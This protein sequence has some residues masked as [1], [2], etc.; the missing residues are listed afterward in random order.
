MPLESDFPG[1]ASRI[2][3]LRI[4]GF[5]DE[6]IE[7]AIV[8]RVE[9]LRRLGTSG[10]E[11]DAWLK[12]RGKETRPSLL[13]DFP[14]DAFE[15]AQRIKDLVETRRQLEAPVESLRPGLPRA[16][17]E[18]F[19]QRLGVT[20]EEAKGGLV[21]VLEGVKQSRSDNPLERLFGVLR[22][23]AGPIRTAFSPLTAFVTRPLA[24]EFVGPALRAVTP[25]H[26]RRDL[27]RF[28][29]Q[30]LGVEAP[31]SEAIAEALLDLF[32]PFSLFGRAPA[33]T[34]PPVPALPPGPPVPRA[35][36]PGVPPL[37]LEA[38]P[39]PLPSGPAVPLP[40]RVAPP[41]ALPPWPGAPTR[42][43]PPAQLE[44]RL[45]P[46]QEVDPRQLLLPF[47]GAI[48]PRPRPPTPPRPPTRPTQLDL[49]LS[50][51]QG[52]DPRQLRLAFEEAPLEAP[53]AP[54][55]FPPPKPEPAPSTV[56]KPA[57]PLVEEPPSHPVAVVA[58][59]LRTQR[60]VE[61]AASRRVQDVVKEIV[62]G[63]GRP[64]R[65]PA[66]EIAKHFSDDEARLVAQRRLLRTRG[67]SAEE[68]LQVVEQLPM[69]KV[70]RLAEA[71]LREFRAGAGG[72]RRGRPRESIE[73]VAERRRAIALTPEAL[74]KIPAKAE[75]LVGEMAPRISPPRPFEVGFGPPPTPPPPS[76]VISLAALRKAAAARGADIVFAENKFRVVESG[77]RTTT[78]DTLS[79]VSAYIS[80]MEAKGLSPVELKVA[81]TGDSVVE[82]AMK[83]EQLTPAHK[84][85]LERQRA[86]AEA[87]VK[88]T[89]L[90]DFTRREIPEPEAFREPVLRPGARLGAAED[91]A[92]L[93]EAQR[94]AEAVRERGL[95]PE[96][97]KKPGG[98][99][100]VFMD[101]MDKE[102]LRGTILYRRFVQKGFKA[103]DAEEHTFLGR[104]FGKSASE[105]GDFLRGHGLAP[106]IAGGA[107]GRALGRLR[108]RVG[109]VVGGE[110]AIER[111]VRTPGTRVKILNPFAGGSISGS[112]LVRTAV[113]D[114]RTAFAAYRDEVVKLSDHLHAARGPISD[115]DAFSLVEGTRLPSTP[116]E[117]AFQAEMQ[118]VKTDFAQ[119]AAAIGHPDARAL[120]FWASHP[121]DL[122]A[123]YQAYRQHIVLAR[124]FNKLDPVLQ[125]KLTPAE[126][127]RAERLMTDVPV[128]SQL[129]APQREF[130][131]KLFDTSG[132]RGLV[133]KF[134]D[135][136]LPR[137]L[138]D[139]YIT[140]R[141]VAPGS[142]SGAV[143]EIVDRT[144]FA[145]HHYPVKKLW[146]QVIRQ[147]PGTESIPITERGFL[148]RVIDQGM[149][150]VRPWDRK[151][152]EAINQ[153]IID[154]FG[155]DLHLL[156]NIEEATS[157]IRNW[158]YRGT[159]GLALD[160]ST[161]NFVGG[162]IYNWLENGRVMGPFFRNL[163]SRKVA[164]PKGLLD[165]HKALIFDYH[166]N[167]PGV[168]SQISRI[169]DKIT[170]IALSPYT[171]VENLLRAN[172]FLS[173]LERA[174]AL[175][176]DDVRAFRVGFAAASSI[177]PPLRM[178][179]AMLRAYQMVERSQIGF[180][181]SS[182]APLITGL[183]PITRLGTV[184]LS[185]P[186]HSAQLAWF[187]ARRGFAKALLNSEP[188]HILRTLAFLGAMIGLP[189][190]VREMGG[191]IE[192]FFG[193][194]NVFN[195]ISFPFFTALR[196]AY[197]VS[198]GRDPIE[199][200]R[201]GREFKDFMLNV[202]VPARR[203]G[204]K[205]AT[206]VEN[207][208]RGYGVDRLGRLVYETTPYGELMRLF[209]IN[210]AQAVN[211]RELAARIH[212]LSL[213][214]RLDKRE[215]IRALI[216]D[217]DMGPLQRYVEE[218]G[219]PI[220]F[221]DIE[222][223]WRQRALR[224]EFRAG[225][226]LPKDVLLRALVEEGE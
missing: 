117:R 63:R 104:L 204:R 170:E 18:V 130:V 164:I 200:D 132:V 167:N 112:P 221:E 186:T 106:P 32:V 43:A 124:S 178:T 40:T 91:F 80:G 61:E 211:A 177:V 155:R 206:V 215:A 116:P 159:L 147:L 176:L 22:A 209:G 149:G 203:F 145:L 151:V 222:R 152:V 76:E 148:R 95:R 27:S 21:D 119:R 137:E 75:G 97:I 180:I 158:F 34:A 175:G 128:F 139:R 94:Y 223:E 144:V 71:E 194:K 189:L 7:R 202:L 77:G 171:I 17:L 154:F 107:G 109:E 157:R 26:V 115:R 198:L 141:R 120:A 214:H 62:S 173:E 31:R 131:M 118:R 163:A 1:I 162:V 101:Q 3:A 74:A 36:P 216:D 28:F 122:E 93:R 219:R 89:H 47:G 126:F 10:E 172:T 8:R 156:D 87:E 90:E 136:L 46:R 102:T 14:Q 174:R 103:L 181:P 190:A 201:A 208:Q 111:P 96:V 98:Y 6:E 37:S 105:I 81:Q 41:P 39:L 30:R 23:I 52:V 135:E 205:V 55:P 160:S 113:A 12:G 82:R 193:V 199:R 169:D 48:G 56:V 185:F 188:S 51:P 226:G 49:Q 13:A 35:L 217:Q 196:N 142:L 195:P 182:R 85:E 218:W 207:I 191:D 69:E 213:Q 5:S 60:Q 25:E 92:T 110:A 220:T 183:G 225:A 210:P 179:E 58:E 11:I 166:K 165:E 54:R 2:Q 45:T 72:G 134:A 38:P 121:S 67:L 44:L 24:E 129:S 4:A 65:R 42:V 197:N 64:I 150:S 143:N 15:A 224:P 88:S 140:R 133:P 57:P 70:R 68:A 78:F 153:S 50:P 99:D 123:V 16:L 20:A 66:E 83:G 100:V 33:P 19:K 192:N 9:Q 114:M 161:A 187:A 86:Q 127:A 59:T 29:E 108:R 146:D 79:E 212:E 138:I 184:F 73:E 53:L 168:L 84:I 125:S